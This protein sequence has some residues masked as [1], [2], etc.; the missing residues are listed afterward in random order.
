MW[1]PSRATSERRAGGA[2]AMNRRLVWILAY[3][4]LIWCVLIGIWYAA[5]P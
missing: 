2:A 3:M 4:A 5:K 1:R